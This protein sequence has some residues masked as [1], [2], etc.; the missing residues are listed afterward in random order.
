MSRLPHLIFDIEGNG[1]YH[2]CTKLHCA[3]T[4]DILTG[5]VRKWVFPQD[6][7]RFLDFIS[8]AEWL[9]AHNGIDYDFPVL[10]KLCGWEPDHDTIITDTLVMSRLLNPDRTPVEGVK[11][12]HSVEAWGKRLGRWKPDIKDWSVFTPEML[13]RCAEDV[14]IQHMI[15]Q[16]L[17]NEAGLRKN[18][19]DIF[20]QES[21]SKNVPNWALAL[22]LEHKS[23]QIFREQQENGV[24]F[25]KEKA[26]EYVDTLDSV[27]ERIT[28]EVVKSIPPKPKQKGVS[29]HEPFK[30]NGE[31]KKAV[32]DWFISEIPCVSTWGDW[33]V[34]GPFSRVGWNSI[35]LGSDI[36]LK[37]WL[38]SIGWEPDEWNYHKTDRDEEGNKLRTSPKITESSL[39][40]LPGGLASKLV[41]RSKASHH[42][43]QIAGWIRNT[44]ADHRI[45]AEANP[46]GTPTGRARHRIVANVPKATVNKETKKLIWYPEEQG[47]FFGTEMRSL[48]SSGPD[49][50]TVL[51]G[52]DATGLELRCLAHYLNDPTYIEILLNGDIHIH[53]QHMAGLETK[54]Q[55]KRFG[56]AWLYGAGDLMLGSIVLPDGSYEE[57]RKVGAARKRQFLT[58]NPKLSGLIKSVKKAS[59]RG[60][61]V[62]IDGRKLMMRTNERG[63][64]AE[65]KA[66]NT[67]L[68]SAGAQ[69]MTYARVWLYDK[70]REL[71]WDKECLKVLDYHDEET[72]ECIS[73]RAED[74]KELMVSSVVEA[75]KFY[76]FNIP[77]DAE[78][79]VGRTWA[80]VH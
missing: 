70:V 76:N 19:W 6:H 20:N 78:A 43:N 1:L 62:G 14:E 46:Q 48:F 21:Y 51:I 68:Q 24:Y 57:K 53:H 41:L 80:E 63:Q 61:L 12:P 8:I 42:R 40:R 10:K 50:D 47:V 15:F 38:F 16:M 49:S 32:E 44:R 65:N 18:E 35:N 11:A 66:L 73:S 79:K 72:Y 64:V 59:R 2:Q 29:I 69:V 71:G 26:Q 30:K 77:L 7:F 55:A 27:V 56:Y 4:K 75:G 22:E 60:Y 34:G 9:C 25:E 3:V 39:E 31:Y 52:R 17:C 67:L 37:N 23:A 33:C 28:E 36:Q 58:A 54:D 74:L 5:E 45:Q 13:H